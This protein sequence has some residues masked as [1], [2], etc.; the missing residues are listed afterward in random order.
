M[1]RKSTADKI[2]DRLAADLPINSRVAIA[3]VADPY[4]KIGEKINVLRST[5]DD[6]LA[7]MRARGQI[8]EAQ[9]AAGRLW[10][11]HYE[12]SEIGSIR[13][14]D[15]SREAVDGG[16]VREIINER[17]SKALKLLRE[18]DVEL[19]QWRSNLV[20]DVLGQRVMLK[21]AAFRRGAVTEREVLKVGREFRA[22]L[23][24]L[25]YLWGFAST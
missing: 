3:V 19:G 22:S 6:P 17:H 9:L 16:R 8:D 18:A 23:D 25:A 12:D 7:G 20:R 4:S 10:Q 14:I 5:R 21:D 11:R 13:A 24:I 1:A 15:P 2:H